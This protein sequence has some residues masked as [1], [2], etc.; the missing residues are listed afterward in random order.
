MKCPVCGN[1][2]EK[3]YIQTGERMSWVKQKNKVSSYPKDGEVM[4][5]NN[6]FLAWFLSR[7]SA[8][9]AKNST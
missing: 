3:G 1:E 8:S 7:L 6:V 4:L 9:H 5:G 2:M